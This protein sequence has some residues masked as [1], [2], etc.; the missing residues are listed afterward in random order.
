MVGTIDSHFHDNDPFH[1]PSDSL[2]KPIEK[3]I[4]GWASGELKPKGIQAAKFAET[5]VDDIVGKGT[6]G[7]IWKGPNSGGI[8]ILSQFAP[9]SLAVSTKT[10][11]SGYTV[12]ICSKNAKIVSQCQDAA[13]SYTQGLKEL[14]AHNDGK[15]PQ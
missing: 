11:I 7:L 1:L 9:Q 15:I 12:I 8:K 13:M 6:A 5:I 10:C 14:K 2:Y 3:Q 4:A